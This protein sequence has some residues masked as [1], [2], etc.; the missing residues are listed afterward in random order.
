MHVTDFAWH[1]RFRSGRQPAKPV[2]Y[3]LHV[4]IAPPTGAFAVMV[5]AA[6]TGEAEKDDYRHFVCTVEVEESENRPGWQDV[7]KA[8][9]IRECLARWET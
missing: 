7:M 6:L 8:A 3:G 1:N 2:V 5:D 9:L 4:Q